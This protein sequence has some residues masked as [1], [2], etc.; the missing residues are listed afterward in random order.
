MIWQVA[1][2]IVLGVVV[3]FLLPIAIAILLTLIPVALAIGAL[4]FAVLNP[5]YLLAVVALVGLVIAISVPFI[6]ITSIRDF[7]GLSVWSKILVLRLTP[8]LSESKKKQIRDDLR[9]LRKKAVNEVFS[10]EEIQKDKQEIYVTSQVAEELVFVE[11]KIRKLAKKFWQKVALSVEAS[12]NEISIFN[13][14]NK[15][16]GI[17]VFKIRV[18]YNSY[19]DFMVYTYRSLS[20]EYCV[21]G[22][23]TD[24][25]SED[26]DVAIKELK[27]RIRDALVALV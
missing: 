10:R 15:S 14:D 5:E 3:L 9:T 27:V 26:F 17:I 6:L 18:K 16:A 22:R 2:G 13:S 21:E 12:N 1:F 11:K 7:G 24:F 23:G 8:A 19:S 20:V 4:V 25:A